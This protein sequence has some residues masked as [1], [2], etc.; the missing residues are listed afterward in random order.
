VLISKR[1]RQKVYLIVVGLYVAVRG[2]VFS[3]VKKRRG[4]MTPIYHF[5]LSGG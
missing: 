1:N 5:V 3:G 4:N 2:M